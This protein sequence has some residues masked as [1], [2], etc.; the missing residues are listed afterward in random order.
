MTQARTQSYG[1][2]VKALENL[3]P[4]KL[5]PDEQALI[6]DAADAL[7]FCSERLDAPAQEALHRVEAQFAELIRSGRWTELTAQALLS[8]VAGC[9]P[10]PLTLHA[11]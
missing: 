1:R 8:D 10:A 2:V 4:T 5:Q 3:G 7:I 9:G 11:V 6:R